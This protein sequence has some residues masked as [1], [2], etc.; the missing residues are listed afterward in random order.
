MGMGSD[1]AETT[2]TWR[3]RAASLGLGSLPFLAILGLWAGIAW[4]LPERHAYLF[5]SPRQT[6]LAFWE[7]RGELMTGTWTS[8]LVLVPG[9]LLAVVAGVIAGLPVGASELGR[10]LFLP[11]ARTAAPVPPTVYVPYAIALLPGFRSAAMAVVFIGAFWPVFLG[12]ATG[13]AQVPA[14]LRDN[15]RVLALSRW[16]YLLIVAAPAAAPHIFSGAAIGLAL[17]FIMLTVAEL[18]GASHGL[19]RFVQYYAD[20]AEYPRMVA[21]IIY[22][23]AVALGALTLLEWIR[24]RLVFW[25]RP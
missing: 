16:R 2:P 19:G 13:A 5:P 17:S 21:G 23:G 3:R 20:L 9:Y 15:A 10:R 7:S 1:M 25:Q 22:T 24:H 4:V 6:V 12:A 8:V 14:R 18:F 11:F